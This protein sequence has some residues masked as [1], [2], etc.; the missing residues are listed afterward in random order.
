MEEA[1]AWLGQFRGRAVREK[2]GIETVTHVTERR[3]WWG[4][5]QTRAN[6]EDFKIVCASEKQEAI[7]RRVMMFAPIGN[8][9]WDVSRRVCTLQVRESGIMRSASAKY[10]L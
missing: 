1:N 9:G 7:D 5:S 8:L 10:K 6:G 4:Y 2:S 3:P